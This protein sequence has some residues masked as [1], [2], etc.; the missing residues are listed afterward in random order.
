MMSNADPGH[1]PHIVRRVL[2]FLD[3]VVW[4]CLAA[5]MTAMALAIFVQVLCRIFFGSAIIWAEEFAVLLFAWS[6]YLG[7][8]YAQKDDSHLGIDTLRL[9]AGRRVGAVL[10]IFRA[11]VIAGCSLVAVWEGIGLTRRALPLLYP[12][13]DI[14]RS[15]LYA[16]VP[17]GFGLILIYLVVS[18]LNRPR[19]N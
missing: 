2:C 5:V 7:A 15:F 9:L 6:I 17:V 10:D 11:T 12:A 19:R 3:G 18:I 13:M 1:A 4:W 16:S 14:T 8:A